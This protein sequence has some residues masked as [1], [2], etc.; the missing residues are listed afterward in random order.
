VGLTEGDGRLRGGVAARCSSARWG[1]HQREGR[2]QLRLA[3][4]AVGEEERGEG[5]PK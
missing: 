3:P 4:G 5:G 2:W 1:P